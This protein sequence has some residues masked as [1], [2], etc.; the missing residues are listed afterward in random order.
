MR[1]KLLEF[2]REGVR[3]TT[4]IDDES[5]YFRADSV[6]LS[7]AERKKLQQLEEQVAAQKHASRLA[8]RVTLDFTGRQVIEEQPMMSAEFEDEIL[9]DIAESTVISAGIEHSMRRSAATRADRA[10]DD[11]HPLLDFPAPIV[12][13]VLLVRYVFHLL[14]TKYSL[15]TR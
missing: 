10:G 5:D 9:R 4:V 14:Y 15:T 12:S 6:W 3:R 2:D 1:N 7:D 11:V 13:I 8:T